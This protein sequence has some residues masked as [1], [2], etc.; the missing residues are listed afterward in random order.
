MLHAF[1]SHLSCNPSER[2]T[3]VTSSIR[4]PREDRLKLAELMFEV[5]LS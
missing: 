2:T 3:I 4:T 1:G 5:N